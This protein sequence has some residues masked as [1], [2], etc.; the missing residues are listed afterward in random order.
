MKAGNTLIDISKICDSY[1]R[2][3]TAMEKRK[4]RNNGRIKQNRDKS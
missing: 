2:K 3:D 4:R 1:Y